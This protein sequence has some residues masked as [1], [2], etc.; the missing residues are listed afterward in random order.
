MVTIVN[1]SE[2]AVVTALQAV[3]DSAIVPNIYQSDVASIKDNPP[4]IVVHGDNYEEW[5]GPGS[6][7]FKVPIE[8]LF[9]SHVKE[10]SP[11]N[12]DAVVSQINNF[13]YNSPAA[14]LSLTANYFCYGFVPTSGEMKVDTE[15]KT[16]DYVVRF[17]LYC[18]PRDNS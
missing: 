17:D 10:T 16:Y 3:V 18:M 7:I 5:V 15:K 11:A 12:R 2:V 4:W 8:C 14:N 6:G 13:I 1:V 9:R